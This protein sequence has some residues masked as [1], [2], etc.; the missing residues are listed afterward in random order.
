MDIETEAVLLSV[1]IA[2]GI[3]LRKFPYTVF[4]G[5]YAY[6]VAIDMH[7]DPHFNVT[8]RTYWASMP[9]SGEFL[10]AE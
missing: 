1:P 10:A 8:Y 6:K 2:L 7:N 9:S 4:P 3:P 5:E